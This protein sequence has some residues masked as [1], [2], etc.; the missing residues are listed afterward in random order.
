M[1]FMTALIF[2]FSV[3]FA[4]CAAGQDLRTQVHRVDATTYTVGNIK[5]DL[6]QHEVSVPGTINDVATL[7]FVANAKNGMKAYE[8]AV[9][10]DTDAITFNT[11]LLLLGLDPKHARVPTKHFDPV[12]PA[13]DAVEVLIEGMVNGTRK[14][15]PIEEL[16]LDRRTNRPMP[17]GPWVYTGSS[18]LRDD[19]QERYLAELDGVLVGFV[20]SPSPII[21][22][23]G[24]GAVKAYGWV[25]LN[26]GAGIEPG[27]TVTLVVRV[28]PHAKR[29]PK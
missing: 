13:G 6:A 16:L 12:P 15:I 29:E 25:V 10:A 20:H 4:V 18:W 21:E 23:P 1:R 26:R 14:R 3:L 19:N 27:S 8:S 17:V 9:S 2:G 5:V 28:A 7:E 22:N 24:A 11:A